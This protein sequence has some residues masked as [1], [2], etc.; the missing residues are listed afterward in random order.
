MCVFFVLLRDQIP[1][2]TENVQYEGVFLVRAQTSV[3]LKNLQLLGH[4]SYLILKLPSLGIVDFVA[5]CTDRVLFWAVREKMLVL[6]V[7]TGGTPGFC[8][9]VRAAHKRNFVGDS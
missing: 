6:A 9:F 4:V 8:V 7:E 2:I 3:Q 1:T 5:T